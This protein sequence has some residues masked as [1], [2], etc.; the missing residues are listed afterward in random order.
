MERGT[1]Q[2]RIIGISD[3]SSGLAKN[4]VQNGFEASGHDLKSTRMDGFE[5]MGGK[6]CR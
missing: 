5:A 2:N 3:M 4:L 1:M 6:Q